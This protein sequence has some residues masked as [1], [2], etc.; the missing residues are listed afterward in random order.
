MLRGWGEVGL[1]PMQR[2]YRLAMSPMT[3]VKVSRSPQ[4]GN[5]KLLVVTTE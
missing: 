5:A 2:E 4:D 1:E 3:S